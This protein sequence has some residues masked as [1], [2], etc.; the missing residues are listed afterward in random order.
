[1]NSLIPKSELTEICETHV[2]WFWNDTVAFYFFVTISLIF[3]LEI[4]IKLIFMRRYKKRVDKYLE[5]RCKALGGD[6]EQIFWRY[7]RGKMGL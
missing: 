1:M 5:D 7:F 4:G 6:E 3:T 2:Y